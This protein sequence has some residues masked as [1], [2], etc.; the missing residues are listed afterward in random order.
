MT[1]PK[2]TL[3]LFLCLALS[4]LNASNAFVEAGKAFK[5]D[6]RLLWAI[7]Y[8]ES[9]HTP[10]IVS[11]PNKNGSY[12]IGIMQ[13]NSSHLVWL[14]KEFGISETDLK[15]NPRIN[16]YIGAL[17]LRKCFDKHKAPLYSALNTATERAYI[18]VSYKNTRAAHQNSTKLANAISCYNGQ[19]TNNP[20]GKEVLDI[21]AKAHKQNSKALAKA[22]ARNYFKAE[23]QK[24]F[25]K[26][27]K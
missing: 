11:K 15:E 27:V 2:L 4:Y 12:D 18:S 5:L 19:I 6:P 13:I 23:R 16:I 8:K 21:L 17:I 26:V 20:Y 9:R 1:M 7:A 24:E 14:N 25:V 10:H 22:R 3:P